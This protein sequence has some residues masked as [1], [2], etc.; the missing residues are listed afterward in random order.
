MAKN[1]ENHSSA[2]QKRVAR[3]VVL[4]AVFPWVIAFFMYLLS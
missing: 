1:L 2:E 3:I 4:M